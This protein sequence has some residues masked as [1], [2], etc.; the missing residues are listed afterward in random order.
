[1]ALP[2]TASDTLVVVAYGAFN[3]AD[4]YTQAQS[5]ARYPL[6]TIDFSAGKNKI[7]NGIFSVWQRG[8]S[9]TYTSS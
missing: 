4:T 3:V 6:N 5:D 8:N 7:I 1:L 9:L 2:A